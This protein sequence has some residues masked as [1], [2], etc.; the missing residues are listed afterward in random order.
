MRVHGQPPN[1]T[2][3]EPATTF[4]RGETVGLQGTV[5]V[6]RGAHEVA[7]VWVKM[8]GDKPVVAGKWTGR[9]SEEHQGQP[10]LMWLGT[11]A[12][13]PIGEYRVGVFKMMGAQAQPVVIRQFW[14]Q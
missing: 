4:A 11:T 8:E 12:N 2:P 5:A 6:V 1:V 9:V 13:H 3:G 14:L 7:V 10:F